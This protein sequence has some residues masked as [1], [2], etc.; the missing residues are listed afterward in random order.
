MRTIEAASTLSAKAWTPAFLN[1]RH[2]WTYD[3]AVMEA[4]MDFD[5]T[6]PNCG[7]NSFIALSMPSHWRGTS[8]QKMLP[9]FFTLKYFGRGFHVA[10]GDG[11]HRRA[12]RE[13]QWIEEPGVARAVA[14]DD[15]NAELLDRRDDGV[16]RE[17]LNVPHEGQDLVLLDHLRNLGDGR[18]RIT[19]VVALE[20][21]DLVPVKAAACVLRRHEGRQRRRDGPNSSPSTPDK[22]LT[23]PTLIS[24]RVAGLHAA[25][26]PKIGWVFTT[27][28][29]DPEALTP[30]PDPPVTGCVPEPL[31][32]PGL[33]PT[34]VFPWA[35]RSVGAVAGCVVSPFAPTAGAAGVVTSPTVSS[36]E[37]VSVTVVASCA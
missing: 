16:Q 23:L 30:P 24:E 6:R 29:T 25:L 7:A 3:G 15:R 10:V 34:G 14:A 12:L 20:V 5:T 19:L 31:P 17:Y 37:V 8:M 32:L 2:C 21:L 1:S 18:G 36:A 26:P 27:F 28:S 33:V 13:Q 4:W 11:L 35:A 22:V 9:R